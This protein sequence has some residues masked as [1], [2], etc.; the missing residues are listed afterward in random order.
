MGKG[1]GK[2]KKGKGFRG[3]FGNSR[4]KKSKIN[5]AKRKKAELQ[6]ERRGKSNQLGILYHL[7][8]VLDNIS[9][10]EKEIAFIR[11]D[12]FG[13]LV[14]SIRQDHFQFSVQ[15]IYSMYGRYDKFVTIDFHP[16][17]PSAQEFGK[18]IMGIF[19]YNRREREDFERELKS[20]V[21]P[22]TNTYA[23]IEPSEMSKLALS[24]VA[25]LKTQGFMSGDV[26][27]IRNRAI[28]PYDSYG[29]K[30]KKQIPGTIQVTFDP[31]GITNSDED[32]LELYLFE[33]RI[34]RNDYPL[35]EVEWDQY[36]A[37]KILHRKTEITEREWNERIYKPN[38]EVIKESIRHHL[39]K[40][41]IN[42]GNKPSHEEIL[43]LKPFYEKR[44]RERTK[45]LEDEIK[46]S[47][48]KS[49]YRILEEHSKVVSELK[50]LT[51]Y[52]EAEN[53]STF[54]AKH[55]IYLDLERYLHIFIRHFSD[56][57]VGD[58]K[59]K[60]TPFQYNF[61]DT[62]RLIKAIIKELQ[63]QIDEALE[64]GKEFKIYDMKAHYYN[65]NYYV[66]HIEKDGRL[67]AFY[68][69]TNE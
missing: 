2:T 52:Y 15:E 17:S 48:N 50:T 49:P 30:G 54:G 16:N 29:D 21:I 28:N 4:L 6:E 60:K 47:A 56:F 63:P 44:V 24:Q 40:R 46:R 64:N 8:K 23:K 7:R 35:I 65:G 14:D 51:F 55:S 19:I 20:K 12:Q 1:D 18:S 45:L 59:S 25:K 58:W 5:R 43:D 38:S 3:S 57:Q 26:F 13:N 37:L 32:K 9:E 11:D 61:E 62:M 42:Q 39:L 53:L 66:V 33:D 22:R 27:E 69:H 36:Y 10:S 34:Q 68:P 41:K 31:K 67:L